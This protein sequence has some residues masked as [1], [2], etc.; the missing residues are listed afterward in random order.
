[1]D[2]QSACRGTRVEQRYN[3]ILRDLTVLVFG[4]LMIALTSFAFATPAHARDL[5]LPID[6]TAPLRL[7]APVEG[8]AIGNTSIAGV[9]VQNERLLFVTGRSYGSTSLVI[10]GQEGR[11]LF[12]GRVVVTPDESGTVVVMR[13]TSMTRMTCE[14]TCRPRPDIGDSPETFGAAANQVSTHASTA[15]SGAR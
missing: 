15:A 14:P 3:N 13:G 1:M 11:V 9:S 10:V 8:V 5:R 7:A 6:T 4:A 12:S 2:S